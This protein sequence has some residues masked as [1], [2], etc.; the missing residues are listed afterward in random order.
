M[1][2]MFMNMCPFAISC[3]FD[4]LISFVNYR[5]KNSSESQFRKLLNLKTGCT[6]RQKTVFSNDM[7]IIQLLLQYLS[8]SFVL[9]ST[10]FFKFLFA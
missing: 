5:K 1:W 2:P 9:K 4:H 6:V 7:R 3:K 10:K 8:L